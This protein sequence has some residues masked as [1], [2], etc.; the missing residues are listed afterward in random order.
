MR[1][2]LSRGIAVC[3]AMVIALAGVAV[4]T[5]GSGVIGPILARGGFADPV[6]IKFKF[7]HE[8]GNTTVNLK[9]AAETVVQQ[10]QLDV[11]GHTGWHS[12]PGPAVV[13]VKSGA[14]TL[15][16][17]DDP[18]CVGHTYTAGQVFVDPGRGNVHLGRNESNVVTELFVTYFDVPPGASPRLDAPDPGNCAF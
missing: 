7:S 8:G 11:A 5:P 4:A 18:A 3:G 10:V 13:V 12:H 15:Y 17:G 14:L 16:E 9:D 1:K 2:L 6:D